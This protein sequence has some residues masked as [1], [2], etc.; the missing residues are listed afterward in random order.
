M[1]RYA[2][3]ITHTPTGKV[4]R[5]LLDC[6]AEQAF[7]VALDMGAIF[8]EGSIRTEWKRVGSGE[9][10]YAT[11]NRFTPKFHTAKQA[12]DWMAGWNGD[13]EPADV[14]A[15]DCMYRHGEAERSAAEALRDEYFGRRDPE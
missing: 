7:V 14:Q 2:V 11:D 6:D 8:P 5:R 15:I 4:M 10:L 1:D 9:L 12:A 3:R 13:P